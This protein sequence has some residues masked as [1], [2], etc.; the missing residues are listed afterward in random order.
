[1]MSL[2][3]SIFALLVAIAFTLAPD[4]FAQKSFEKASAS[5]RQLIS[6]TVKGNQ[7]F[8]EREIIAA[9]GLRL[10]ETVTEDDFKKAAERLGE[11][12]VFSDV[13]YSYSY[14]GLGTKLVLQVT[15]ATKFVPVHFEDFVWFS[16]DDLLQRI[17]E[18]APLFHGELPLSGRLADHV[19]DVLQ[20]LLVENAIP[21]HVVYERG[22][23]QDGPVDS[24]VYKVEDVVIQIRNV[25]FIGA[26]PQEITALKAAS[27]R[28]RDTEYSRT[29]LNALVQHQLTPVYQAQ[30]YLKASFS[31]PQTKVVK[32]P[33]PES[34]EGIRNL[35]IVDVTFA[36]IPGQQ[37]KLKGV[38]W[39][40]NHEFP[41]DTLQKMVRAQPGQPPNTIRLAD[42]LKDI[43]KLYGSRGYVT[44]TIKVNAD[45]DDP[46][47]TV[48]FRLDVNEGPV[49]SMGD[50]EFRGLDNSLEAKLR[51]LWKIRQGEVYNATYLS[52]YLPAARKLLP[53]SV[54][55]DVASHVTANVKD[56]TVD[57]DLI[58]SA[59]A[60]R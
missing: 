54:D 56:K 9:C 37:Y 22:G 51:N 44:T 40:G 55:W 52:E 17:R 32:K 11:F 46:A 6:I 48:L 38:E 27:D 26:A 39:S 24:I 5:E 3:S 21:G 45:F 47:G 58:Y 20:A 50:L 1:M 43:Q 15:E 23:K 41:T 42:N 4:A 49:F 30:G 2:R 7:R 60:T 35:T 14:S 19:S 25:D 33:S 13:G 57:V 36:V 31:A 10:G 8:S 59:K 12:G 16:D 34:D 29:I 28:V 53:T 18:R